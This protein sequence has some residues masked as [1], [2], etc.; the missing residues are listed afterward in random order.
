MRIR[1]SSDLSPHAWAWCDRAS[2]SCA[3]DRALGQ[4]VCGEILENKLKGAG[5]HSRFKPK[6]RVDAFTL[7]KRA[8]R[9]KRPSSGRSRP[10][11]CWPRV[12][13]CP[14][15]TVVRLYSSLH[16]EGRLVLGP[17]TEPPNSAF[18]FQDTPLPLRVNT[19]FSLF[20]ASTKTLCATPVGRVTTPLGEETLVPGG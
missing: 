12:R 19:L 10:F 1:R 4:G 14:P 20:L 6:N 7:R 17:L 18:Q 16:S 8:A 2:A 3:H 5:F 9:L 15:L 11:H 13:E